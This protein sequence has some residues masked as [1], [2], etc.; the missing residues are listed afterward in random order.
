M[1]G[2]DKEKRPAPQPPPAPPMLFGQTVSETPPPSPTE[3]IVPLP[4]TVQNIQ[5]IPL[6]GLDLENEDQ[7]VD[8]PDDTKSLNVMDIKRALECKLSKRYYLY[9][10][11][12]FTLIN[13]DLVNHHQLR[14]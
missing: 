2:M 13:N 7:T 8:L 6:P 11:Y 1:Q 4:S 3:P 12:S 10:F 9:N 14:N 5:D